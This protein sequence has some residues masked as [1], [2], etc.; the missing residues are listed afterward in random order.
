MSGLGLPGQAGE[1]VQPPAQR[2]GTQ[3]LR[4]RPG[5]GVFLARGRFQIR[6]AGVA[7]AR[8]GGTL[9]R[10]G[11]EDGSLTRLG[12]TCSVPRAPAFPDLRSSPQ[13]PG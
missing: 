6:G 3:S 1:G 2:R 12:G 7:M 8:S 9:V 10:P 13:P 4:K 5:D 11:Y